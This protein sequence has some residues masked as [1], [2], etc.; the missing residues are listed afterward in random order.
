MTDKNVIKQ[1]LITCKPFLQ[2]NFHVKRIGFFGSY[3]RGQ[4]TDNSDVD[5]L[6]E[7]SRPV[8]LQFIALK[9]YLENNLANQ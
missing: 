6:V 7:F 8:G 2:Q 1:N 3:A 5:V 9:E 4:Q